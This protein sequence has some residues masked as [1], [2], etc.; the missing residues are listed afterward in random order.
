M[1]RTTGFRARLARRRNPQNYF[2]QTHSSPWWIVRYAHR[3]RFDTALEL[4][5]SSRPTVVVD[6]GA[7]DGMFV[8][9][10]LRG[11]GHR[12]ELVIA[13][14]PLPLMLDRIA[15]RLEGHPEAD[16]VVI[17]GTL[18]EVDQALAGR[19]VDVCVALEVLEH[20]TLRPRRAFYDFAARHL[21]ADGSLVLGLPVEIGPAVIVKELGRRALKGRKSSYTWPELFK[22]AVGRTRPDPDRFD[23]AEPEDFFA[24]H[25]GFDHRYVLAELAD[26]YRIAQRRPTPVRFAPAW[27]FNQEVTVRAVP[28]RSPGDRGPK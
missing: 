19:P 16:R 27:L 5:L 11:D 3:Q 9:D 22:R 20:L 14:D 21:A 2:E 24:Y 28:R 7:G 4:V 6:Y 26:D 17:C 8:D 1:S 13:F 23:A 15:E 18:D 25:T 10:L 12:P